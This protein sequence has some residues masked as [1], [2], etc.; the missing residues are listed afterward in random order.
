LLL[1]CKLVVVELLL[2][3]VVEGFVEIATTCGGG[4]SVRRCALLLRVVALRFGAALLLS[5]LLRTEP[6]NI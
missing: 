3:F 5:S 6:V 1:G 4:Y 2:L